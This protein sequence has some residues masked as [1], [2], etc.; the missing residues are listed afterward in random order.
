MKITVNYKRA[1]WVVIFPAVVFILLGI[2]VFPYIVFMR[3]NI[4]SGWGVVITLFIGLPLA[5]IITK[6]LNSL[7][8]LPMSAQKTAELELHGCKFHW[9]MNNKKYSI[10]FNEKYGAEVFAGISVNVK[11]GARIDLANGQNSISISMTGISQVEVSQYFSDQYFIN[12]AVGLAKEG[13]YGLDLNYQDLNERE[14]LQALLKVLWNHKDTNLRY[15]VCRTFSWNKDPNPADKFVS[16]LNVTNQIDVQAIELFKIRSLGSVE[17]DYTK[18]W[19][20][21]DY[22]LI[23]VNLSHADIARDL[24]LSREDLKMNYYLMPIGYINVHEYKSNGASGYY[25]LGHYIYF[26]GVLKNG[27]TVKSF[28]ITYPRGPIDYSSKNAIQY[29]KVD[30]L[31][32]FIETKRKT[33]K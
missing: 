3:L 18:C 6:L 22:I 23:P 27:Q 30:Y 10:D 16:L 8:S 12:P 15:Q 17:D 33:R 19:F 4:M 13:A 24:L 25:A 29:L 11:D 5:G 26:S 32:R 9:V 31:K 1:Q 2:I 28:Y 21:A 20:D 14:L 7:I